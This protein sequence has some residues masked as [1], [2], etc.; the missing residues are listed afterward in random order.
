MSTL[1]VTSHCIST[2]HDIIMA[3]AP[4]QCAH[5][6]RVGSQRGLL[7]AGRRPADQSGNAQARARV[8]LLVPVAQVTAAEVA[9]DRALGLAQADTGLWGML[10]ER[11][12]Q[13]MQAAQVSDS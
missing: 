2:Y 6:R 3:F 10:E 1:P 11:P 8:R 4:V 13:D 12:E 9:L 5:K 7:V